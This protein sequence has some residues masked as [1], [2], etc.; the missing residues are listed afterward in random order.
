MRLAKPLTSEKG[1][2]ILE[3]DTG[4][5]VGLYETDFALWAERNAELLRS[6]RVGEAD[7]ENIAEEIRTPPG[8]RT[9]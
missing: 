7:L 5:S 9:G 4:G 3:R 6:G 8:A 1:H 2:R